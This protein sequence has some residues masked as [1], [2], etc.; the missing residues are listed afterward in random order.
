M[1]IPS[2]G[3]TS[4]VCVDILGL[5]VGFMVTIVS[6]TLGIFLIYP[7]LSVGFVEEKVRCSGAVAF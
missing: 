4:N 7:W 1:M 3:V 2:N 6:Q 5:A